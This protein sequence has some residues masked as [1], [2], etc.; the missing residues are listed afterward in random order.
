MSTNK[1]IALTIFLIIVSVLGIIIAVNSALDSV[2][3]LTAI[4]TDIDY[5]HHEVTAE[6]CNGNLW[7][8]SGSA[9]W[10]RGDCVSLVINDRGTAEIF[11]D[12]VESVR[13]NS[14]N[15]SR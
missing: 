14:W 10:A 2:Y 3:A 5:I 7:K 13:Y 6:D 1:F 4:V 9:D 11:D 8:F 15:L 12:I